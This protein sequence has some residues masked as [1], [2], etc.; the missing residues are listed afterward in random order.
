MV[1]TF[2]RYCQQLSNLLYSIVNYCLLAVYYL[3]IEMATHSS[4]LAW[5]IAQAVEPGVLQS[6]GSQ[7]VRPTW[8]QWA[9]T[10]YI[11]F[12]KHIHLTAGSLSPSANIP[13]LPPVLSNHRSTLSF[14]LVHF[15]DSAYSWGYTAFV[16]LCLTYL[17]K[18]SCPWT[19]YN[20]FRILEFTMWYFCIRLSTSQE[21]LSPAIYWLETTD[22]PLTTPETG[23]QQLV[24]PDLTALGLY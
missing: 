6:V 17:D 12:P 24:C 19:S 22:S 11:K 5:R 14:L 7:R 15:L 10:P 21:V 16:F 9:C 3:E 18:F 2:K 23:V 1:I 20:S 8:S 13:S 4:I